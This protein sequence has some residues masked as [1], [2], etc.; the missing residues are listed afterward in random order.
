MP[1]HIEQS[2]GNDVLGSDDEPD[3]NVDDEGSESDTIGD[4]LD[5]EDDEGDPVDASANSAEVRVMSPAQLR[6]HAV[7]GWTTHTETTF[8]YIMDDTGLQPS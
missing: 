3:V 6:Q 5:E 7:S 2:T 1:A 4:L 8:K